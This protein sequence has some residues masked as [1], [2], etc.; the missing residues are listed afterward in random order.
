METLYRSKQVDC[1]WREKRKTKLYLYIRVTC[2]AHVHGLCKRSMARPYS[3]LECIQTRPS[4]QDMCLD[5]EYDTCQLSFWGVESEREQVA[6]CKQMDN[7][8]TYSQS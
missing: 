6:F 2:Y 8:A 3:D 7:N 5:C 4:R 1:R